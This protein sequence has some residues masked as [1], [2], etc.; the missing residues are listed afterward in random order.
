MAPA[1]V[2]RRQVYSWQPRA[3]PPPAATGAV[4]RNF[5][6]Q[7]F[8]R[9][10]EQLYGSGMKTKINPARNVTA[11]V[12]LALAAFLAGCSTQVNNETSAMPPALVAPA[13][14]PRPAR[15]LVTDFAASPGIVQLDP[16]RGAQA[17]RAASGMSPRQAAISDV[18]GVQTSLS[19]ALV[20][21]I[22]A[23]GLP[24]VRV[25][26]GTMPGA[27]EILVTGQITS[28]QEGNRARRVIIGLGAGKAVVQGSAELLRGTATGPLVLQTYSTSANSGRMP[29][30]GVGAAA[31]GV[32]SAGTAI[33][34]AAHG[35]SEIA[36]TP[37]EEEAV[38]IANHLS[39]ELGQYFAAQNWIP[40]SAVPSALP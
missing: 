27:G 11:G 33:S 22:E 36:H 3:A 16:S 31:S 12:A 19:D 9:A 40:A 26:A 29:G 10:A 25:P 5:P 24:A 23:M 20:Q 2:A 39:V 18:L 28:I 4:P 7:P 38:H 8:P 37:V 14:S 35:A 34:G 17:Q 30:M 1:E 13:A 32:K 21:K 6:G 15:I